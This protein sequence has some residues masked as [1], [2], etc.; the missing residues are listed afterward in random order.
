V[1]FKR[2]VTLYFGERLGWFLGEPRVEILPTSS[3]SIVHLTPGPPPIPTPT[4][5]PTP[6][7]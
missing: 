2:G 6:T 1:R 3:V 7:R 5:T 4:P